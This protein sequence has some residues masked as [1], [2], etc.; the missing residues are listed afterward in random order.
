MQSKLKHIKIKISSRTLNIILNRPSK[1]NALNP[2][3]I[4]EIQNT[5]NKYHNENSIRTIMISSN[6]DVFCA[7]ADIKYLQKIKKFSY[8][9]NLKD[10]LQ[11]MQLFKTMLLYPKI[12]ISKVT[13]P[14]I[15]GGCGI[16][17]ASDMVFATKTGKF[18]YPEVKIGFIPA[19]VSTFLIKK[20]GEINARELLLTGKIINTEQAKEIGLI[21]Y[22]YN[23][24]NIDQ[25]ITKFIKNTSKKTSLHSISETKKMIYDWLDL[26]TQL[27]KAAKYN[28]K[29][30]KTEDFKIGINSFLNKTA[31]NWEK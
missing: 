21:N 9:E 22:I 3:M 29:H 18:G 11:L 2:D 6:S 25:E 4:Q 14:A 7:G 13:G 30:R 31:I 16:V 20:I 12:I 27:Q 15:G 17:T 26:D 24:Q 23:K 19:L 1:K 8:E 5:F 28:A 10:S